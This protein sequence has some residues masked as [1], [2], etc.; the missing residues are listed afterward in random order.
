ML[1]SFYKSKEW[2][3]W[4]YGGGLALIVSLWLQVRMSVAINNWYGGF[5]D[6]LQN[7]EKYIDKPEE[8]IS[9]NLITNKISNPKTT[10][11]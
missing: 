3:K 2:A 8:G 7:A 11:I 6:L 9:S 10:S 4:A 5:Y 1:K